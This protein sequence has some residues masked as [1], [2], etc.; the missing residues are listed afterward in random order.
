[1][2][3]QGVS[4]EPGAVHGI[5][6]HSANPATLQKVQ[7]LLTSG[8]IIMIFHSKIDFSMSSH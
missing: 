5:F 6:S 8:P 2:S 7:M 4:R 3:R 1:M